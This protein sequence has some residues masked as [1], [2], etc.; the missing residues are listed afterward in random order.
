V[1]QSCG[2]HAACGKHLQM[3][4][5]IASKMYGKPCKHSQPC[6]VFRLSVSNSPAA[7]GLL[8]C[9]PAC[10]AS[11]AAQPAPCPILGQNKQQRCTSF[12]LWLSLVSISCLS[13]V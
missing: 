12:N 13:A 11:S 6:A 2:N 3:Y 1:R 10:T 8:V 4:T 5:C 9:L 7:L